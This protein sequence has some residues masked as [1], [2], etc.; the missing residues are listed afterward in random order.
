VG[1][2]HHALGFDEGEVKGMARALLEVLDA[3]SVRLSESARR[4]IEDS[5]GALSCA[6]AEL[7][8]GDRDGPTGR[9]VLLRVWSEHRGHGVGGGCRSRPSFQGFAE[10]SQPVQ[11]TQPSTSPEQSPGQL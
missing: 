1:K 10:S 6:W 8:N 7:G 5:G 9:A 11:T 2:K 3:Q 4:R